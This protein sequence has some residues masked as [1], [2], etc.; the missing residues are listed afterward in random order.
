MRVGDIRYGHTTKD[1]V[2]VVNGINKIKYLSGQYSGMRY[3]GRRPAN[4]PLLIRRPV[5]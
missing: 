4:Y 2:I 5:P 1:V 3:S